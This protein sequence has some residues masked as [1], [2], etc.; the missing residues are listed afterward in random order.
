MEQYKSMIRKVVVLAAL[1]LAMPLIAEEARQR[2]TIV[3]N[4]DA[5]RTQ[6]LRQL[7][8]VIDVVVLERIAGLDQQDLRHGTSSLEARRVS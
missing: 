5:P 8:E 2:Y 7:T 6:A 1:V 3:T 4:P